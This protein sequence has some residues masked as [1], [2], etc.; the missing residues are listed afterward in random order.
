MLH[1][2][3]LVG[4]LEANVPRDDEARKTLERGLFARNIMACEGA[5]TYKQWLGLS[6]F[7]L[8]MS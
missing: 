8:F 4:M 1:Y 5:E 6:S 3:S 7:L 2:S